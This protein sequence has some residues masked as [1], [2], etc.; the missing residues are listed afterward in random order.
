MSEYS[1]NSYGVD[2]KFLESENKMI[3][4]FGWYMSVFP[5]Q[6]WEP[7][8]FDIFNKVK[9]KTKIALDI[10]GWIGSTTIWLSK[11]FEKVIVVEADNNAVNALTSNLKRNDCNN[12]DIIHKVI[13]NNTKKEI[14][15]GYN[16]NVN[17]QL[18][19][20]MSQSKLE[21]ISSQDYFME[22][23]TLSDIVEQYS[24]NKIGFVKV[25]IEGGEEDIFEDL[26]EISEKNGWKVW[27]SFHYGWWKD[28]NINRFDDCLKQVKKIFFSNTEINKED[29]FNYVMN[30][31]LGTFYLEF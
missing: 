12:V 11:H 7:D 8:T 19:D 5:N 14:F 15:F 10:G 30:N 29:F 22:T 25:D 1:F 6:N 31:H 9:D 21:S 18:G 3:P 28:K 16:P 13:Y 4:S 2:Y 23:I 24:E 26:F 20:S 17:S 27:L